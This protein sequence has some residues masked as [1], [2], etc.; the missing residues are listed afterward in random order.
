MIKRKICMLGAYA[1]GKTSLVESFVRS[2]FSEK[3]LTTVGVRIEKKRVTLD[4]TPVDLLIW[5]IQGEDEGRAIAMDYL[6]GVSGCVFVADGTRR[7]TLET[8]R[9]IRARVAAA[10]GEAPSILLLNKRDRTEDWEVCLE[11]EEALR[12]EGWGVYRTSAK[13]REGVDMAF[14]TLARQVC[15][16]AVER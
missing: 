11:D 12:A 3:Y 14:E 2:M 13:T 1:V 6:R 16:K 5:D 4:G 7:E 8:V 10:I 15:G 9:A